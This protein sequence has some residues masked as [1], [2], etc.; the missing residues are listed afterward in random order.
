MLSGSFWLVHML[1]KDYSDYVSVPVVAS[2]N[3]EGRAERSTSEVIIS[4]RCEASGFGLMNLSQRRR[5]VPL[6]I[7]AVD[8]T[9][10]NSDFFSISASDLEKYIPE[11]FGPSVTVSSFAAK[12]FQFRFARENYKKVPVSVS[13]VLNFRSQYMPLHEF[14]VTPDSVFIYGEPK[15][16]RNISVVRTSQIVLNDV[17]GSIHGS[18]G[19]IQPK[20]VRVS[21]RKV[22]YSLDVTRFVE[23]ETTVPILTRNA[24]DSTHFLVLPS[25][26]KVVYKCIFPVE[27]SPLDKA[28]FYVDYLDFARSVSGKCLVHCDDLP[29]S[30]IDYSVTP[31]VC[32]CIEQ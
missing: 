22:E 7:D 17:S 8:F 9:H 23:I 11:I 30:V 25:S 20:G 28:E 10:E 3:I 18:V 6:F 14:T 21:S 32:D 29:A 27:E 16:L 2:S 4:A 26:A 13:P 1:S 12:S 24:P 5:A 31:Q 15:M 19:L